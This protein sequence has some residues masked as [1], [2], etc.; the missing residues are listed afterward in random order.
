MRRESLWRPAS[1][2]VPP[3]LTD[4]RLGKPGMSFEPALGW[5]ALVTGLV[6]HS[7]APPSVHG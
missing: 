7:V 1:V 3:K 6:A 4:L 5:M 2:R